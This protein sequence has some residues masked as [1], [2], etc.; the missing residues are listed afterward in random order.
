MVTI[1]WA[2]TRSLGMDILS[3][4]LGKLSISPLHLTI[5]F[6]PQLGLDGFGL[7]IMWLMARSFNPKQL[8]PSISARHVIKM[9]LSNLNASSWTWL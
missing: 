3:M 7:T 6:N 1:Y 4:K 5:H 2:S 8:Y 9:S